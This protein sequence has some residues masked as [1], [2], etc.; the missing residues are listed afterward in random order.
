[1]DNQTLP[2]DSRAV[3]HTLTASRALLGVV[4]RSLTGTMDSV[5]LPQFR[6]LVLLSSRGP[7]RVGDLAHLLGVHQSSFSR[8][9]D[10]MEV[11]GLIVRGQSPESRR[12]VLV[13]ATE[14]GLRIVEEVTEAR[15]REVAAILARVGPGDKEKI[16]LGFA[17]FAQAAGEPAPADSLLLGI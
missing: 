17:L 8:T 5:S 15:R 7:A 1:M 11:A 10:R 6:A 14:K 9:A 12:E 4:A 16:A 2:T 13:S 3:E